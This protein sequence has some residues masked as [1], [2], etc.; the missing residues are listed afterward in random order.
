MGTSNLFL[1]L[2]LLCLMF[3]DIFFLARSV[4]YYIGTL[5][6]FLMRVYPFL[7]NYSRYSYPSLEVLLHEEQSICLNC[8]NLLHVCLFSF[9]ICSLLFIPIVS[10]CIVLLICNNIIVLKFPSLGM[11]LY[12]NY[13]IDYSEHSF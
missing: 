3:C 9:C 5:F 1:P 12:L 13:H 2:Q 11:I 8:H 6:F 4:T 7:S 10:I